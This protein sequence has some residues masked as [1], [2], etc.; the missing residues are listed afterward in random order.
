LTKRTTSGPKAAPEAGLEACGAQ[1]VG[2]RRDQAVELLFHLAQARLDP[3]PL[4]PGLA[5]AAVHPGVEGR[6]ERL[7]QVRLHQIVLPRPG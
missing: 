4:V 1:T 2:D 5:A 3:P 6:D 7:H